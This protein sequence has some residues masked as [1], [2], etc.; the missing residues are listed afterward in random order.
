MQA[1]RTPGDSDS[2]QHICSGSSWARRRRWSR[3]W[4][5]RLAPPGRAHRESLPVPGRTGRAPPAA[6]GYGAGR[7]PRRL[8]RQEGRWARA[9][10][11][12]LG[13]RL[14]TGALVQAPSRVRSCD[15][16]PNLNLVTTFPVQKCVWPWETFA[17]HPV[18]QPQWD[19]DSDLAQDTRSVDLSFLPVVDTGPPASAVAAQCRW[20]T[21]LSPTMPEP[22]GVMAAASGGARA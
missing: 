13:C 19:G 3:R 5:G 6:G 15:G 2:D 7:L 20:R 10:P 12:G 17:P 22:D 1:T 4:N 9:E 11:T 8:A 16:G 21:A 14:C 18:E